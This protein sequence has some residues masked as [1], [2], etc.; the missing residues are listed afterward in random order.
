MNLNKNFLT[1]VIKYLISRGVTLADVLDTFNEHFNTSDILEKS[2][3]RFP[4]SSGRG[5]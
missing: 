1:E 2:S 3:C 5:C 4:A